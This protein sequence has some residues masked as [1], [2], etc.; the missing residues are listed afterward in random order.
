MQVKFSVKKYKLKLFAAA[1]SQ[2]LV[3]LE[4]FPL[5]VNIENNNKLLDLE[6]LNL[7]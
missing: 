6:D 1:A 7:C 4:L 2:Q 3:I 5:I